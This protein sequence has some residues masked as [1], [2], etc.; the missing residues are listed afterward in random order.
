MRIITLRNQIAV[1]AEINTNSKLFSEASARTNTDAFGHALATFLLTTCALLVVALPCR[2]NHIQ[3]REPFV[4]KETPSV[5]TTKL[6]AVQKEVVQ[7]K[8]SDFG[9]SVALSGD[10]MIVGAATNVPDRQQG[11][12]YIFVRTGNSWKQQ[13]QLAPNTKTAYGFGLS[14]ALSG[15]TAVISAPYERL[16]KNSSRGA[17]YV[18]VRQG[19][20]WKQQQKLIASNS[21][22]ASEAEFDWNRAEFGANVAISRDTIVVGSPYEGVDPTS[23]FQGAA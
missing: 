8:M 1:K 15:D 3:P 5:V 18:F 9:H 21:A 17:V 11:T 2:A 14:V 4:E 22:K 23:Y 19:T 16:N 13:S 7:G 20:K 12:A 10:T 6:E